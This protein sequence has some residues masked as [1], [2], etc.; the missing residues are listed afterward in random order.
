MSE[1]RNKFDETCRGTVPVA[2]R[3]LCESD[4]FEDAIR[5]A[6]S[7]GADA[8]TLAAIVGSVAERIWGIPEWMKQEALKHLP[9]EMRILIDDFREYI[10]KIKKLSGRCRYFQYGKTFADPGTMKAYAI[11]KRW[12]YDLARSYGHANQAKLALHHLNAIV[13]WQE[14]ADKYHV[15]Q[16][17]LWYV[18]D[19]V[20]PG[21]IST[22]VC[23]GRLEA[24]LDK[25]YN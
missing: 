1:T 16:S 12:V 3:I 9:G 7:H 19:T 20:A 6:V 2:M 18:I 17:F 14:I 5:K 25:Y 24:F 13:D 11:E 15:P 22:C 21:K 4:S 10:G 23:K 8:D